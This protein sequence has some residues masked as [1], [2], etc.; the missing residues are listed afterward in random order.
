ME[1]C[2]NFVISLNQKIKLNLVLKQSGTEKTIKLLGGWENFCK[3][4]NI[5]GPMDFLHLFD[6]MDDVQSEE[7]EDWTLFRYKKGHN[8]MIY[9]RKNEEVYINYDEILHHISYLIEKR[10]F[11]VRSGNNVQIYSDNIELKNKDPQW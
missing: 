2:L 4:F 6:D 5:E 9:N 8:F 11:G 10:L 7:K 3:V 1:G